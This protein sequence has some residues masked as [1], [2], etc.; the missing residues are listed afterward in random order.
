MIIRLCLKDKSSILIEYPSIAQ[1]QMDLNK[2]PFILVKNYRTEKHELYSS[3]YVWCA[4]ISS[5]NET[6]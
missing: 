1:L 2:T 3:D 6:E 5:Q 4:R